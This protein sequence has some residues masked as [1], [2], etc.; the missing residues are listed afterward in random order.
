MMNPIKVLFFILA[1]IAVLILVEFPYDRDS[2]ED[3]EA[4]QQQYGQEHIPSVDHQKLAALKGPFT[5]PQ[6]VTR[7][8]ISCHTERHI[9]VMQSSH[10]NWEEEAY[11]PG[12]GIT[13]AGKK[14]LLNNFCIG[15]GGSETS[16]TKCHAG[17]GWT[18]AGFDFTEEENVDCLVCHDQS[19]Q[20]V[21]DSGAAGYPAGDVDLALAARSV[22]IPTKSNCGSC[23][24][25][26]GG[27]NNVKHGDLEEALLTS[28]RTVDVHMGYDGVNMDCIACH[29]TERHQMK[30]Q[31]YAVSS[32]NENRATCTECH[33]NAPHRDNILNEHTIKVACQTCHIPEYAK[34]NATKM[35]WDWSKA[36]RLEN[37]EPYHEED[38]D[39]NHTYLSI[40][41]EFVW[42]K[43]VKPE[44][45]W[46]NGT[47]DHYFLG[48]KVDPAEVVQ[49]N[50]LN[51]EYN[52]PNSQIIP[53]K[54]HRARQIYDCELEQIIHRNF[55]R[56]KRRRW[57]LERF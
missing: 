26:S 38:E 9:E 50:T 23:H 17:Y 37:G 2:G 24:F 49:M 28:D 20:Y 31:L 57:L 52:D 4:M 29:Q 5:Y 16:C 7:Q 40:K 42:E 12:R 35:S 33:S 47:A 36:G 53:V 48:D 25:Y 1:T 45:I 13:Y 39:G 6:E 43:N 51:G 41:G 46:F 15:I 14:N 34:V 30:G 54:I 32:M 27:G 10:W 56:R 55:L 8:C 18:D 19:G 11:I 21:K 22:G 44:Y 3:L